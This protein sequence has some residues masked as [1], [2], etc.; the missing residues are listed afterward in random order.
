M[1]QIS[2][3][4]LWR[5]EDMLRALRAVEE[6]GVSVRQAAKINNV[7]RMTL[8]DRV[9]GRVTHGHKSGQGLLLTDQD[10]QALVQYCL[11]SAGHGFPLTK[12]QLLAFATAIRYVQYYICTPQ[13]TYCKSNSYIYILLKEEER[14]YRHQAPL[15]EMVAELPPA[16]PWHS[17][18]EGAGQHRPRSSLV[19]QGEKCGAVLRTT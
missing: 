13:N 16:S 19:C 5:E 2:K 12:A 14:P 6:E 9:K 7:P 17:H 18:H 1:S 11:Y 4:K 15:Q 8:A 3:R 10:E